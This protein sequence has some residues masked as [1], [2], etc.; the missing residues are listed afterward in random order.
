MEEHIRKLKKKGLKVTPRRLAMISLFA[1]SGKHLT[2]EEVWGLLRKNFK[3]CGFPGVYRNLE[4]LAECGILTRIKQ[5]DRK[6]HY[7]LCTAGK[8][9]HHHITCVEC[10]K[11][12][13]IG[14][15]AIEGKKKIKKFEVLGHFVQIDGIC[16]DCSTG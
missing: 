13:D 1:E 2:P 4:S 12:E 6:R 9:H 10:G 3:K 16:P 8:G 15:C 5:S 14:T 7:G 11:V